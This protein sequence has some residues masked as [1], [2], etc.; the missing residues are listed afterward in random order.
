MCFARAVIWARSPGCWCRT[1][2]SVWRRRIW[3]AETDL[4]CAIAENIA[5]DKDLTKTL[6]KACGV[7]VPEGE[8]VDSPAAA[9][10]AA[11]DIG[12]PVV[13]KPL[14]G[15]HGRGVS[16]ELMTQA[17]V[18]AAAKLSNLH[19]DVAAWP[20]GYDRFVGELGSQLSGGQQ[21]RL[22]I[23]RALVEKPELLVLDE[24]TSA[25]DVES[26]HLIR[27]TLEAL[28][29]KVSVVIIAH[30]LST[31][32]ICDRIMVV[33]DGELQAFDT[34]ARLAVDSEFYQRALKLSGLG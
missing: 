24:P 9:W 14:D 17:D 20:E 5:G 34:P 22:V 7:S 18:E 3:T 29:G 25:L 28:R 31:L 6:L 11:Q 26:E 21:Q 2:P 10:E 33:H 23:A 15:N 27:A 4:T 32:D 30:R 12:L 8:V 19:G 13:I 1:S 16:L